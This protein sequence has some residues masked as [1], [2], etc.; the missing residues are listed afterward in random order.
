MELSSC[1]PPAAAKAPLGARLCSA[2]AFAGI[3]SGLSQTLDRMS[4]F[5]LRRLGTV[6]ACGP[7]EDLYLA[8]LGG[9]LPPVLADVDPAV[10]PAG[11][12]RRD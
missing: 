11:R 7:C 5:A 4:R 8:G 1:S 9:L 10:V 3:Q 2:Y 12:L 6:L